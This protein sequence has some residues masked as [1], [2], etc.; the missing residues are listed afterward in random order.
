MAFEKFRDSD[1][2]AMP[3]FWAKYKNAINGLCFQ[4]LAHALS[5]DLSTLLVDNRLTP[6]AASFG[7]VGLCRLMT[8]ERLVS[9]LS[10]FSESAAW[11]VDGDPALRWKGSASPETTMTGEKPIPSRQRDPWNKGRMTG[12]KRPLKPK[13]VWTI[14]VC[15]HLLI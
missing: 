2:C 1:A 13:D 5:T 3:N 10:A 8:G 11:P 9:A 15:H 4:I 12:Q 7:S 14:R 6:G